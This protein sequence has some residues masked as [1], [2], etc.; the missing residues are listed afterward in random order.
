MVW[1]W[2]ST[3][4]IYGMAS[5][6]IDQPPAPESLGWV[7]P[8]AI[9][10]SDDRAAVGFVFDVLRESDGKQVSIPIELLMD[11]ENAMRVLAKLQ[12]YQRLFRIPIPQDVLES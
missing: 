7:V 3:N 11:T 10:I 1:F 8:R 12:E 4:Q 5:P 6:P 9:R 2:V